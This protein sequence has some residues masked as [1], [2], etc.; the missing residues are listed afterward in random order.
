[1]QWLARALAATSAR[2]AARAKALHA[3][4]WLAHFLHDSTSARALLEESL[5]IARELDDRWTVA[6]ALHVL[7]RVAYFDGDQPGARA[8]G[9]QSLA[10][11][12]R[13]EDRWLIAWAIHLLGLA[14]HIAGDYAA[15]D[16]RYAQSMAIRR[17]L[18]HREMVGVLCQLMGMSAY[19]QGD[20]RKAR[21]LYCEYLDI[22]REF[23]SNFHISMLLAQFGS[24]AAVH[25]QPERA[26]RLMAAAAVFHETSGTRPIP[27][28]AAL[29]TDGMGLVREVL[30]QPAFEAAWTVGRAMSSDEAIAEA[31][32]VDITDQ[33]GSA[34]H[35]HPLT[36][37]EQQV[38][39]L[40]AR[41]WTNRQ[42]AVELVVGERT[43]AT[44][45]EHILTKLDFV[46]RT[47]IGVW[48]SANL[49]HIGRSA[50][51]QSA[52]QT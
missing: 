4:G 1:V 49:A 3:A 31:L 16:A 48:I 15:A 29:V 52:G 13:L 7:G 17:A 37:R 8:F 27:L 10:I 12:E 38:A 50:D 5:S 43:V 26:A 35:T 30:S 9:E 28:T 14:A 33:A 18:G 6:W 36:K 39:A 40:I 20:F 44:H 47:Q 11:A 19:R 2:S 42:I 23:G 34:A 24:L 51:A 46:S 22:A 45:I 32:A 41:G 25:G 21:A